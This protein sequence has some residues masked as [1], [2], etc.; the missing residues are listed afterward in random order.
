MAASVFTVSR[1]LVGWLVSEGDRIA[2]VFSSQHWAL[3]GADALAYQRHAGTGD[4]AMV[5]LRYS[6][7][8]AVITCRYG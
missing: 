2:E 3:K 8:R 1:T 4:P 7:G 6:G 5:V